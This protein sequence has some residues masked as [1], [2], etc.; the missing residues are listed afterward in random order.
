MSS[1]LSHLATLVIRLRGSKRDFRSVE[2]TL[3]RIQRQV[4]HP[5]SFEPPARLGAVRR[6][7][8]GWPVFEVGPPDSPSRALLLHGGVYAYEIDP[9]HWRL[10]DDLVRRT[11][12]RFTVPI[13]TL[14]PL[15][16]A[17]V[18]V[19][20]VADLAE[21][22]IAGVGESRVSVVGDSSGGGMALAVAMVLRDRGHAPLRRIVLS[23]PWLDI[24]GT[25]P[26]LLEL[27]PSD[28]WLAVPGTRAAG[29]LYRGDLAVD[30]PLVS[31]LFGSL[32]GL[33][34][35]T[36]FCGTRD[37]LLADAERFIPLAMAAGMALDAHIE[38]GMI[39]NFPLLPTPEGRAARKLIAEAIS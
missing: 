12:I 26:R 9:F 23:A 38:P 16:T 28:P 2:R 15:A 6:E 36:L 25:D 22:L 37:I 8:R 27:D 21:Q 29:G 5:A 39:H 19:P 3:A 7:W 34:P 1:L 33:A 11:G 35:V 18:T 20:A 31:P 13:M 4:E 14:A 32:E 10:V 30:D 24:S 17:D